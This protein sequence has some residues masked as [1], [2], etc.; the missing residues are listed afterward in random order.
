MFL[1][2]RH[3][4]ISAALF[5]LAGAPLDCD[6]SSHALVV[7]RIG[8]LFATLITTPTLMALIAVDAVVYVSLDALVITVS[9]GLGVAIGA[10]EDR[11][12]VRIRVA[13]GAHS[14]GIAVIDRERCVLGMIEGC[15]EPVRGVVARLA[16]RG[17]ELRLGGV[18]RIG[19]VV[20]VSLV[21]ANAGGRK[22]C[23]V[24]VD[25][26]VCALPRG[27]GMRTRQGKRSVVVIESGIGPHRGVVAQIALLWESGGNM[28]GIRGSLIVLQM[29]CNAGR[30]AQGVVVVDMAISA[31][32]RRNCVHT[33]QR[34]ARTGVVEDAVRPEQGVVAGFT[35]GG[36]IGRH[37]VHGAERGVVVSLVAGDA[38]C[39]G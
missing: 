9:L 10:L 34:K 30:A 6:K 32:P 12:V 3:F 18:P 4:L 23:V 19:G 38:R 7:E 26:A 2:C 21:A 8:G 17:E 31:L 25:V 5:S 15:V 14:V 20:V 39:V 28:V 37:M 33:G 22:R 27:N 35:R 16:G 11:V 36:E 1:C 13:G 24:V 29:A